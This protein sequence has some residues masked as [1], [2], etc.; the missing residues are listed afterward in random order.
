MYLQTK[1]VV[2]IFIVT[3]I[4]SLSLISYLY[5][6]TKNTIPQISVVTS[7]ELSFKISF[8]QNITDGFSVTS[9]DD[10]QLARYGSSLYQISNSSSAQF[11]NI[12]NSSEMIIVVGDA[13]N[14]FLEESV[15]NNVD[16]QFV[17]IENSMSYSYDNVYQININYNEIYDAI[18]RVSNEHEKSLLITTNEYS[19][20]SSLAFYDHE[21]ATNPYVKI[22]VIDS[23]SDLAELATLI[24]KDLKNGFTNIYS[25]DPYNGTTILE[26][27]NQFNQDNAT[28]RL[29][30]E[31]ASEQSSE[32]TSEEISETSSE[33]ETMEQAI[34][35]K[36]ATLHHLELNSNEYLAAQSDVETVT[37]IYDIKEQIANVASATLKQELKTGNIKVSIVKQ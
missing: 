17:L 10:Q 22:E 15:S 9:T 35:Y 20:A 24:Q 31:K 27:A 6:E 11:N 36:D 1:K 29:A 2:I 8:A 32:E 23:T 21:I 37:Y 30:N 7:E 34:E 33:A 5:R 28:K 4:T 26:T 25:L 3:I 12:I 13:F 14:D 18:N 16:K 19:E